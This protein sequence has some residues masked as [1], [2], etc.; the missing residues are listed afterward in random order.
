MV[1]HRVNRFSRFDNHGSRFWRRLRCDDGLDQRNQ[2]RRFTGADTMQCDTAEIHFQ[3]SLSVTQR[4]F[5]RVVETGSVEIAEQAG[6]IFC[7]V[8]RAGQ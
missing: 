2:R 7:G 5:A 4:N 1:M 3:R 8:V 6:D